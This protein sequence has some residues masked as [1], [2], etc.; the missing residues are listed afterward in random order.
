MTEQR[1]LSRPEGPIRARL[2]R[3]GIA[4]SGLCAVH[5]ILGLVLVGVL[6]LGGE[7]LLAPEVHEYGLVAAIV[8]GMLTIGLGAMRHGRRLPLALG[9]GGIALMALAVIGPHGVMEAVLTVAG[10]AI[11]AL[12]HVLNIRACP[13]PR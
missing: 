13:V 3:W 1:P 9:G 4:L 11:L 2:D 8:I 10:V 7:L 6:G 5:C 12:G